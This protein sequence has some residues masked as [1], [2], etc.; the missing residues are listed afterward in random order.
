MR[1]LALLRKTLLEN[2]RDWKILVLVITFAPFFVALMHF[3]YGEGT[4]TYRVAVVDD[5]R[6]SLGRQLLAGMQEVG[7]LDGQTALRV[8]PADALDPALERLR[9]RGVDLVVELPEELSEAVLGY[10]DGRRAAPAVVRTW[11]DPSNVRSPMAAAF[12]DY[13]VFAYAGTVTG[14]TGPIHLE[15][16]TLGGEGSSSE[17]DHYVPALLVLAVMMLMFTAAASLIRE[18]DAGTIVRLRLSPMRTV[19]W[20]GAISVVQVLIGLAA[21]GVTYGTAVVLGYRAEGAMLPML[22]VGAL[23]S[24]SVVAISI[25]VAAYLRTIFDLVTIG[26]FPFFVLMFFSGGMFPLPDVP[27][28]SVG[29]RVIELNE[30]LPTTHAVSA[31]SRIMSAGGG[32]TDVVF[33]LVAM[34]ALTLVFFA[35]GAWLFARRHLRAG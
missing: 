26:C 5:D 22:V 20:L 29:A 6:G 14:E 31:L 18:K 17:F 4:T 33:E 25:G 9:A 3:Y 1:V 30:V 23:S 28:F 32:L 12:I 13:L 7:S 35:V 24:L 15:A 8:E 21:L 27:L 2:M 19:E 11:G 34:A 10:R 16:R